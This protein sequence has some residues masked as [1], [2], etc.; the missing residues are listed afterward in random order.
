MNSRRTVM[1]LIGALAIS[2]ACTLWIGH[3]LD[4]KP[5][6]PA[7][8]VTYVVAAKPVAAGEVIQAASLK[9]VA[10]PKDLQLQ[11]GFRRMASVTG[12]ALRFPGSSTTG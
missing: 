10:W 12:R 3:R 7:P 9:Q 8:Q 1:A 6:L 5:A 11:G 4:R 2:G